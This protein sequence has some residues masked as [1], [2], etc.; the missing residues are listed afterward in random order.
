MRAEGKGGKGIE[1]EGRREMIEKIF[2]SFCLINEH[3]WPH[4]LIAYSLV[5]YKMKALF[6]I[7]HRYNQATQRNY[8]SVRKPHTCIHFHIF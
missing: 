5:D 3:S 4:I 2:P 1:G 7:I 8:K 6:Q